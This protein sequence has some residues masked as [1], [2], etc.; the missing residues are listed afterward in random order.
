[1]TVH[2]EPKGRWLN[3]AVE[4]YRTQCAAHFECLIK[5]RTL[6]AAPMGLSVL[7]PKGTLRS[8]SE[9]FHGYS[10]IRQG[11][12]MIINIGSVHSG[13]ALLEMNWSWSRKKSGGNIA[14]CADAP[15]SSRN[16]SS[17]TNRCVTSAQEASGS[18]ARDKC[19][20]A[21]GH[22]SDTI[23]KWL[24]YDACW[25]HEI[26]CILVHCVSSVESHKTLLMHAA[27]GLGRR[28]KKGAACSLGEEGPETAT[29]PAT[30]LAKKKPK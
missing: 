29:A 11:Q 3:F 6:G 22:V 16:D 24:D 12:Q 1:M 28:E 26:G 10:W 17:P 2:F 4:S 5:A 9:L 30:D 23:L 7:R 13:P 21:E 8:L 14:F 19:S 27:R 15:S 25:Q 18:M 20:A